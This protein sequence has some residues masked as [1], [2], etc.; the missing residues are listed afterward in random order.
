MHIFYLYSVL[1]GNFITELNFVLC[2]TGVSARAVSAVLNYTHILPSHTP[3]TL[4]VATR[5]KIEKGMWDWQERGAHLLK[6]MYC[7]AWFPKPHVGTLSHRQ[8]HHCLREEEELGQNSSTV[9]FHCW[10]QLCRH[11]RHKPRT[12]PVGFQC[13]QTQNKIHLEVLCQLCTNWCAVNQLFSRSKCKASQVL[14]TWK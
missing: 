2:L 11:A 6:F 10:A 14:I 9:W 12:W 13:L 5:N 8:L 7:S 3:C 1:P 4:I